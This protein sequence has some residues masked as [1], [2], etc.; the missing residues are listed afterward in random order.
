MG[1]LAISYTTLTPVLNFRKRKKKTAYIPHW[2]G[3]ARR[4][5]AAAGDARGGL[6][7]ELEEVVVQ[8][9]IKP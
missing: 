3:E 2:R 5:V 9:V 8:A 6:K 7:V 4:Q 1:L